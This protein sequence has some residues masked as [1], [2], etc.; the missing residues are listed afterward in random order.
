MGRRQPAPRRHGFARPFPVA[1]RATAHGPDP[2]SPIRTAKELPPLSRKTV[3]IRHDDYD[4]DVSSIDTCPDDV[5]IMG[6]KSNAILQRWFAQIA[7]QIKRTLREL[8][9]DD[10]SGEEKRELEERL[11]GLLTTCR[12]RTG[13]CKHNVV[14]SYLLQC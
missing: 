13:A 7:Q 10:L 2:P 11:K 1:L 12:E 6:L 4:G 8:H 3:L 14:L 9:R 5:V